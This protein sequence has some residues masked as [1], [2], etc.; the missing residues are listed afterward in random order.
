M[1]WS[2]FHPL[3]CKEWISNIKEDAFSYS[4]RAENKCGFHSRLT[5]PEAITMLPGTL[6]C[7]FKMQSKLLAFQ[8]CWNDLLI[9]RQYVIPLHHWYISAHFCPFVYPTLVVT[10]FLFSHLFF[11]HLYE[12]SE[13]VE[14]HRLSL[15]CQGNHCFLWVHIGSAILFQKMQY[16]I[17]S[18]SLVKLL[19][20]LMKPI[21]LWYW[22]C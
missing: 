12:T 6:K 14:P 2:T 16:M 9:P 8:S 17:V 13:A 20:Q 22:K 1:Y 10:H 11:G 7:Q 21:Y 5:I 18:N 19:L 3:L 4:S 15:K